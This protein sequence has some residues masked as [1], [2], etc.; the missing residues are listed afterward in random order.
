ME[1]RDNHWL[2]RDC[3]RCVWKSIEGHCTSWNCEPLYRDKLK[4]YLRTNPEVKED[5][6]A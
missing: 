4:E 1:N 6:T 5:L 3:K 2:D